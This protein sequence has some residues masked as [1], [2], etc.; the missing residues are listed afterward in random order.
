MLTNGN[1]TR[2]KAHHQFQAPRAGERAEHWTARTQ[3]RLSNVGL[4]NSA[5]WPRSLY[6]TG[7]ARDVEMPVLTASGLQGLNT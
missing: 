1:L 3:T 5:T 6:M 7:G 4:R 2:K